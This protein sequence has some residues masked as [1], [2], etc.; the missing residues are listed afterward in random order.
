MATRQERT[1]SP[2]RRGWPRLALLAAMLG[3][4]GLAYAGGLHRYL[5]W[6]TLRGNV[7]AWRDFTRRNLATAALVYFAVYVGLTSMSFPVSGAM[8]ILG[9]ALFDRWLGG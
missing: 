5:D 8:T 2:R 9:G 1:D 3:V 7:Q 4:L 6:D